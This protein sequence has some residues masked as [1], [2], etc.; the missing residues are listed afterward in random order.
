M[1][2]LAHT[3]GWIIPLKMGHLIPL[4][5]DSSLLNLN[6]VTQF[7]GNDRLSS[8]KKISFWSPNLF[9]KYKALKKKVTASESLV[10]A[11]HLKNTISWQQT[12]EVLIH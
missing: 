4:L 5:S 12:V 6:G 8:V 3:D 11:R 1:N 10:T 9:L 2:F 7:E